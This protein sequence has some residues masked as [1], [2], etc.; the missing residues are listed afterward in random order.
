MDDDPTSLG[1]SAWRDRWSTGWL[2]QASRLESMLDPVDGPLLAVAA[3]APGESVVDIGCGRGATARRV[4]ELVG[5]TGHVIGVD[6]SEELIDAAR[7]LPQPDDDAATIDWVAADAA[8]VDLDRPVDLVV[9]RFGVMFFDEPVVAFAN[10]VR[11]TRR[12]GRLAV[13]VWL[14]RTESEFQRRALETAVAD[15]ARRG[16]DLRLPDPVSGPFRYG[17][18]DWVREMLEGSGWRDVGVDRRWLD[19]H[20]GGPGTSPAEAAALGMANGPLAM[21]TGGLDPTT[22][23]SIETAVAADLARAWD[24]TGV[25]LTAGVSIVTARRP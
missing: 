10:L 8:T 20:V 21:L 9:S 15:A 14:P 6:I 22:R 16:I 12:G 7:S 24:G 11:A 17:D 3:P 1:S 4:A 23:S 25:R 19:L 2:S 18:T 13:A 5:S